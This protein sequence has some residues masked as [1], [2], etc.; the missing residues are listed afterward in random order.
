MRWLFTAKNG[1]VMK[2]S[3]LNAT[4]GALK[5]ALLDRVLHGKGSPAAEGR[6]SDGGNVASARHIFANALLSSGQCVPLDEDA[7]T[8]L[9]VREAGRGDGVVAVIALAP[10]GGDPA[11]EAS[12]RGGSAPQRFTCEYRVKPDGTSAASS[13]VAKATKL[14]LQTSMTTYVLVSQGLLRDS[15]A[16][17]NEPPHDHD[18]EN[19]DASGAAAGVATAA[20]ATATATLDERLVSRVKATNREVEAKLRAVVQWVQ[21]TRSVHVLNMTATF[22][23]VPSSGNSVGTPG[24]WLERALHVRML[25]MDRPALA[26]AAAA[27]APIAEPREIAPVV[28]RRGGSQEPPLTSPSGKG[29][30]QNQTPEGA[31]VQQPAQNGPAQQPS[32]HGSGNLQEPL[33][34]ERGR[35][36]QSEAPKR[37]VENL[38]T[39]ESM[40]EVSKP[41]PTAPVSP[42]KSR[43]GTTSPF[44]STAE[45]LSSAANAILSAGQA[46]GASRERLQ[47]LEVSSGT[48]TAIDVLRQPRGGGEVRVG[49]HRPLTA[50]DAPGHQRAGGYSAEHGSDAASVSPPPFSV[51]NALPAGREKCGGDFCA[52]VSGGRAGEVGSPGSPERSPGQSGRLEERSQESRGGEGEADKKS[53]GSEVGTTERAETA[54]GID[55]TDIGVSDDKNGAALL[56]LGN[57]R[58]G[59]SSPGDRRTGGEHDYDF[60]FSLTFKSVA[61]ARAEARRGRNAYWGEDLRECWR[62]GRRHAAGSSEELSPALVYREVRRISASTGGRNL[63]GMTLSPLRGKCKKK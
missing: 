15:D 32:Q 25:P 42:P 63:T 12:R 40:E 27:P 20:K 7:W 58:K 55:W 23:V 49:G 48:N 13:K 28:P 54:A 31:G 35:S 52:Y 34:Q 24:V 59:S 8:A 9:V 10:A 47:P 37:A 3:S 44:Q 16:R 11:I 29:G 39:R 22:A 1:R 4:L 33:F 46:S 5:Q 36:L 19:N 14:P 57:K 38:V 18:K 41:L 56:K 2:K 51:V 62:E 26:N 50:M 43:P 53:G 61:L 17:P 30:P 6:G 21:D 60:T 45:M